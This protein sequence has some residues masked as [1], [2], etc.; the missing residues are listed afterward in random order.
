MLLEPVAN[1]V[2]QARIRKCHEISEPQPRAA[3]DNHRFYPVCHAC[4]V[5][6]G[7]GLQQSL[8]LPGVLR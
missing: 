5:A 7:Q 6:S 2:S 1:Q 8:C 4:E 3:T